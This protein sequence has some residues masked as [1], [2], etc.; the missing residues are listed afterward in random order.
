LL[1]ADRPGER[2]TLGGRLFI[3][4][5]AGSNHPAA[6][7]KHLSTRAS[8]GLEI[9]PNPLQPAV[10]GLDRLASIDEGPERDPAAFIAGL[11]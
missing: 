6:G 7:G 9:L 10:N 4:R 3:A 2:P 8:A 1:C 11:Q 5:V